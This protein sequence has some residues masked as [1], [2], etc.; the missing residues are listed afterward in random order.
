MR[1]NLTVAEIGIFLLASQMW[2]LSRLLPF[3]IHD[4]IPDENADW[5]LFADLMKIVDLLFSPVVKKE[6]TFYLAI[7]IQEYLQEF[8]EAFPA[9]TIIPKMHFMVHY[10]AQ[11]RRQVKYV[12][13]PNRNC[14]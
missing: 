12:V 7:L 4:L 1:V 13:R 14:T 3:L 5:Q 11:I 10:P 6:T 8:K 2:C 9:I